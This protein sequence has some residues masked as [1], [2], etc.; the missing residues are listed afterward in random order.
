MNVRAPLCMTRSEEHSP[1]APPVDTAN[2]VPVVVSGAFY[3]A[4]VGKGFYLDNGK[5]IKRRLPRLNEC[6]AAHRTYPTFQDYVNDRA[7]MPANLILFAGTWAEDPGEAP[8]LT[9]KRAAWKEGQHGPSEVLVASKDHLDHRDVPTVMRIDIDFKQP[10]EVAGLT[11]GTCPQWDSPKDAVAALLRAVPELGGISYLARDSTSAMIYDDAGTQLRGPGGFRIEF[12]V[13]SG[14]DVP[15]NLEVLHYRCLAA[16]LGW[17]FVDRAG[18]VHVRSPV[19]LAMKVQTQPDFSKPDLGPG[20]V[21]NRRACAFTD[22]RALDR[23]P[24]LTFDQKQLAKGAVAALEAALVGKAQATRD[25][26]REVALA[27][28]LAASPGISA[29]EARKAV[30]HVERGELLPAVVLVF[31]DGEAVTVGQ[32]LTGGAEYDGRACLDPVEPSY[33]DG[34]AVGKFYWNDGVRPG[35]HSFAHGGRWYALRTTPALMR[36]VDDIAEFVRLGG[37]IN[38][39]PIADVEFHAVLKVFAREKKTTMETLRSAIEQT[40][41]QWVAENSRD[42]LPEFDRQRKEYPPGQTPFDVRV[43][44]PVWRTNARGDVIILPHRDN[45]V[46]LL[47]GY[48]IEVGYDVFLKSPRWSC[49]QLG[50]ERSDNAE[51]LRSHVIGQAAV[52]RLPREAVDTHVASIA[53]QTLINPVVE[54]FEGLTWDGQ[55][56]VQAA[57]DAMGLD[58]LGEVERMMVWRWMLQ[59]CAMADQCQRGMA[60]NPEAM[61]RGETVLVLGGPQGVGKTKA[62]ERLVPAALRRYVVTGL[63]G[64]DLANKDSLWKS[65][66]G[67]IVELGELEA[68]FKKSDQ[69]VMKAHLSQHTDTFRPPYLYAPIDFPRVTSYCGSVNHTEFLND[70]TGARRYVPVDV[71][72]ETTLGTWSQEEIGQLWAQLWASYTSGEQWWPTEAEKRHLEGVVEEYRQALSLEEVLKS[73]F[74]FD[75]LK[76]D[77]EMEVGS[78]RM[79]F[80]DFLGS[81]SHRVPIGVHV[82]AHDFSQAMRALWRVSGRLNRKSEVLVRDG[83]K[84][85]FPAKVY[86]GSGKNRGWLVPPLRAANRSEWEVR[87][88]GGRDP[89]NVVGLG[90]RKF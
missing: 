75:G 49:A 25:A 37:L 89:D 52:C 36:E 63:T 20:L 68:M 71:I 77:P 76:A 32:L 83:M 43:D 9:K 81:Y 86:A 23:L 44:M 67:W 10:D 40:R 78:A 74:D 88:T 24:E 12:H 29:A 21:Q 19:D 47:A 6:T 60:V 13:R 56:R 5:L 85:R 17:A 50:E 45:L 46:A 72:Q 18:R 62:I 48:G 3:R 90:R 82:Q 16:G 28:S 79:S 69:G 54:L 53:R 14:I 65:I 58:E 51:L 11:M 35:V 34:R 70:T 26:R 41:K 87:A 15:H 57:I 84:R 39:D 22:G 73:V 66:R 38:S 30:E 42:G 27:A 59:C 8:I 1:P 31:E 55:D 64:I 4:P 7:D 2:P 61:H 80:G 33:D